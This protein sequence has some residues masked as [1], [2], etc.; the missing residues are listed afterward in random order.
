[1]WWSEPLLGGPGCPSACEGPTAGAEGTADGGQHLHPGGAHLIRLPR[2]RGKAGG[3]TVQLQGATA[4]QVELRTMLGRTPPC[5]QP[6]QSPGLHCLARTWRSNSRPCEPS[7]SRSVPT[8]ASRGAPSSLHAP[9]AMLGPPTSCSPGEL[10]VSTSMAHGWE[11][12]GPAGRASPVPHSAEP[13]ARGLAGAKQT[14]QGLGAGTQ[15]RGT[16]FSV[17]ALP[18]QGRAA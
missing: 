7:P 1:M 13:P 11:T 17:R 6:S 4:A 2:T 15:D 3:H 12:A 9:R 8:A 16:C 18:W 10:G 5:P 14:H